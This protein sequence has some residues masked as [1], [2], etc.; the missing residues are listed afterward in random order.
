MRDVFRSQFP[1]ALVV[2]QVI[3]AVGQCQSAL[4]RFRDLL[5][6]VAEV[7]LS[8]ETEQHGHT[9]FVKAGDDDRQIVRVAQVSEHLQI[10]FDRCQRF[11]FDDRLVHAG[12]VKD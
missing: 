1:R 3:V 12:G 6:C 9:D 4:V 8:A 10:R 5:C 7:G 2:F 11:L